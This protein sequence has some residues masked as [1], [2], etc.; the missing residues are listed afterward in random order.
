MSHQPPV[1]MHALVQQIR[2]NELETPDDVR[3]QLNLIERLVAGISPAD[4]YEAAT[5]EALIEIANALGTVVD[6]GDQIAPGMDLPE[7]VIP[8]LQDANVRLEE[9]VQGI[10]DTTNLPVGLQGRAAVDIPN[11]SEG[12]ATFDFSGGSYAAVVEADEAIDRFER[13]RIKDAGNLAT[14]IPTAEQAG[15]EPI[16]RV[17]VYNQT[18]NSGANILS[19]SIRPR[20]ERSSFRVTITTDTNAQFQAREIPDDDPAFTTAFNAINGDIIA[21]SLFEF[22]HDVN[23]NAQYNY[24]VDSNLDVQ[25]LRI[26]EVFD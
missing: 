2:E 25:S 26:L 22:T 13:I 4:D 6:Q 16:A 8:L 15:Q 11:G 1:E 3:E 20:S 21:D 10:V 17:Q 23:P 12:I 24:R 9:I 5:I 14:P 18:V 19:N 7:Q